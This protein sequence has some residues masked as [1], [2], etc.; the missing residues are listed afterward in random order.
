MKNHE[1]IIWEAEGIKLSYNSAELWP[2]IMYMSGILAGYCLFDKEE[3]TA[4]RDALKQ[5]LWTLSQK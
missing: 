5:H 2:Y 3:I 4:L 1:E